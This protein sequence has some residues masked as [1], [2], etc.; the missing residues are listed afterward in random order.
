MTNPKVAENLLLGSAHDL[1]YAENVRQFSEENQDP[2]IDDTYVDGELGQMAM[3]YI[4]ACSPEAEVADIFSFWP[5]GES[6][7]DLPRSLREGSSLRRMVISG[8]L[9]AAEIQR[10]QRAARMGGGN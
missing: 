3:A 2:T 6:V 5:F 8:A 4:T 10:L 9:V 7:E 1:I